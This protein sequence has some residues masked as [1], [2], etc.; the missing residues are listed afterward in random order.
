MKLSL[1]DEKKRE[2]VL[3]LL[4]IEEISIIRYQDLTDDNKKIKRDKDREKYYLS[5]GISPPPPRRKIPSPEERRL[6]KIEFHKQYYLKNI[7]KIKKQRLERRQNLTDEQ[8]DRLK[9]S[10]KKWMKKYKK[11]KGF[12]KHIK[13]TE[14]VRK[15]KKKEYDKLYRQNM[16]E[17]QKERR[18]ESIRKYMSR[19]RGYPVKKRVHFTEEEMKDKKER[20][21][22]YKDEKQKERRRKIKDEKRNLK[23]KKVEITSWWKKLF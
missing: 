8:K 1:K 9:E 7:E 17:E 22:K 2:L 14:K 23:S 11:K 19:I 15:N 10:H 18:R 5:K 3:K 16:T 21:R 20:R 6:E 12:K 13:Q 4:S